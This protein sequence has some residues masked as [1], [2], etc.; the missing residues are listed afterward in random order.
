MKVDWQEQMGLWL[1][2][3]HWAFKPH[4]PRQ[5]SMHFWLTQAF[6]SEHSELVTHSG[7]QV[8]GLPIKP[9]TQEHTAWLLI[10]LHWLLGPQGEGLHGFL[11]GWAKNVS[12]LDRTSDII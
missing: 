3:W 9:G 2:T 7:L 12:M 4:V 11:L 5:G 1:T 8:G 10:S 6:W